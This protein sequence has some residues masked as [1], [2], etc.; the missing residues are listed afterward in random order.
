LRSG[1]LH[2][3]SIIEHIRAGGLAVAAI[4]RV[5]MIIDDWGR[6]NV[7]AEQC[8]DLLEIL[9]DRQSGGRTE[10]VADPQTYLD[11]ARP[12]FCFFPDRKGNNVGRPS[13]ASRS[14]TKPWSPSGC[15]A[16]RE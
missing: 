5:E 16:S 4:A 8:R 6:A 2:E 9:D 14:I 1:A 11:K 7:I 12:D 3:Q 10:S 13:A 15:P